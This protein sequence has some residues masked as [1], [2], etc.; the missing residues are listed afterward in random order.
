VWVQLKSCQNIERRGRQVHYQP[1]DWVD[2]G[3]QL[4]LR[5]IAQGAAWVPE[6]CV[7]AFIN[8]RDTGVVI[9]AHHKV[10]ATALGDFK[11]QLNV[12]FGEPRLL[13]TNNLFWN[14]QQPLRPELIPIGFHLL[15]TW[16][17]AC[18]LLPYEK[19]AN[20][21]GNREDQERTKELIH[22]LRVPLYSPHLIFAKRCDDV[23]YMMDC[24]DEERVDSGCAELSLLRAIYRAKPL[25]LALPATWVSPKYLK[26]EDW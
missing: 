23:Q 17:V 8:T 16:Q 11:D 2:V 25:V 19:L 18:P 24:W 12:E 9:T 7:S 10:G 22:D 13:W 14:P 20:T 3:K 1:G 5:W 6:I 4:A 15:Q 26:D 21:V